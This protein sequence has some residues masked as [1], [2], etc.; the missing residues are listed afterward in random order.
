MDPTRNVSR[1]ADKFCGE[2]N[3]LPPNACL[4]NISRPLNADFLK[5]L[6]GGENSSLSEEEMSEAVA[7]EAAEPKDPEQARLEANDRVASVSD[8]IAAAASFARGAELQ[9][10]Q[11]LVGRGSSLERS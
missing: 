8:G 5:D 4:A 11:K 9:R 1:A 10:Q 2:T 7:A 6:N 3:G